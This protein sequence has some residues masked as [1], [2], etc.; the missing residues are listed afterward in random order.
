[1]FT[2]AEDKALEAGP[3]WH[4]TALGWVEEADRYITRIPV[5]SERF[6]GIKYQDNVTNTF[7]LAYTAY[8]PTSGHDNEFLDTLSQLSYDIQTNCDEKY[9]ILIGL[10]ST[11]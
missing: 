11:K 10:D 4:G 5:I 8:L 9:C 7:I 1:M 6:C 3:T 2:P